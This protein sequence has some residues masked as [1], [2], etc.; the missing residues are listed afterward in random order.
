[1]EDIALIE[2][3]QRG[4]QLAFE[5]LL[6][7][8]QRLLDAHTS[9]FY[10]P[11]GDADDV[12][13]EARIGF[14]KAVRFYRGGRGSSFHT[15]AEL[16]VSRQLAGAITAARRSKHQPLNES[17]R[18]EQAE[19]QSAA[20]PDRE[21]PLEQV[22]ARDQLADLVR[23]TGEFSELERRALA[24]VLAGWSERRGGQ[25]ARAAPPQHRQRGAAGEAKARRLAGA[26]GGLTPGQGA[27]ARANRCGRVGPRSEARR[28]E[29]MISPISLFQLVRRLQR[30]PTP[31]GSP[32]SALSERCW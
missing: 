20:V 1:M 26:R 21:D 2:A 25:A 13:Q 31:W 19:R 4:D 17:V 23:Q 29:C 22:V 11:D 16:C 15:F 24:H 32:P 28:S 14:M 3:A 6:R 7:R 5:R 9:R 18:D 10:L 27:S 30:L 12:V 8:Y